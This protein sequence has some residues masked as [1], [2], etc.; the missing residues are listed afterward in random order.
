[1]NS[2]GKVFHPGHE[3]LHGVTVVVGGGSGRVYVGRYHETTIRGVVL[4]DVATHM[5]GQD[6]LTREAWI[7]RQARFGVRAENRLVVVPNEEVESIAR[8]VELIR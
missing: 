5:P 8:L 1:M 4:H 7:D 6:G 3:A 2:M